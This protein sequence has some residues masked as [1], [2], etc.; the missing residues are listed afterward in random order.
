ML[1]LL[2]LCYNLQTNALSERLIEENEI[3]CHGPRMEQNQ[4]SPKVVV[5]FNS[6]AEVEGIDEQSKLLLGI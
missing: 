5:K 6:K 3:G 1:Q 4:T 2:S